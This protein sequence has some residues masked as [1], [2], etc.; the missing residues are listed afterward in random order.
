MAQGQK[1]SSEPQLSLTIQDG[2]CSFQLIPGE[3]GY[4][5][6]SAEGKSRVCAPVRPYAA[7]W[8]GSHRSCHSLCSRTDDAWGSDCLLFFLGGGKVSCKCRDH[9]DGSSWGPVLWNAMREAALQIRHQAWDKIHSTWSAAI[10]L[11]LQRSPRD[12]CRPGAGGWICLY[13]ST[14]VTEEPFWDAGKPPCE[15]KV[16]WTPRA[17]MSVLA[18]WKLQKEGF[19][20]ICA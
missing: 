4:N 8:G 18:D 13:Q 11:S 1:R 7:L 15:Q 6:I 12:L 17:G 3:Q 19:A 14:A 5:G 16:H 20:E 2:N 9:V 10:I